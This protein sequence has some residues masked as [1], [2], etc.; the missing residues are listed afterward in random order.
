MVQE[1]LYIKIQGSP[2]KSLFAFDQIYLIEGTSL[3]KWINSFLFVVQCCSPLAA[4]QYQWLHCLP[5]LKTCARY[6]DTSF[7][8]VLSLVMSC[9]L[10]EELSLSAQ[11]HCQHKMT[12]EMFSSSSYALL[13]PR[14]KSICCFLCFLCSKWCTA[15]F[16]LLSLVAFGR[17]PEFTSQHLAN[18]AWVWFPVALTQL[19]MI[20]FW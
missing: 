16:L 18:M 9:I 12:L 1:K 20:W 10:N 7:F 19:Q 14:S 8:I 15:L 3:W 4:K 11:N 2:E 17:L 5:A 13:K 6:R